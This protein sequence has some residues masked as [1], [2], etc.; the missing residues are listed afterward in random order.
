MGFMEYLER[1]ESIPKK[2]VVVKKV[3]KIVEHKEEIK[4]EKQINKPQTLVEHVNNILGGTEFKPGK[5]E[6]TGG[7]SVEHLNALLG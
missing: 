3:E 7:D 2:H 5:I 4:E 1:Q 6:L